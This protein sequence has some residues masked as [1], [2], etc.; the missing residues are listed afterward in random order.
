M[1]P[2]LADRLEEHVRVF[3]EEIGASIVRELFLMLGT[4]SISNGAPWVTM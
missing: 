3:A 2:P 4:T 1:A